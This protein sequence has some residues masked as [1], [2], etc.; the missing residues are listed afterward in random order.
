MSVRRPSS[1]PVWRAPSLGGARPD[2]GLRTTACDERHRA[3]EELERGLKEEGRLN[4]ER[5][6]ALSKVAAHPRR[7]A[8]AVRKFDRA[9][10]RPPYH[11]R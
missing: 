1:L 3:Q 7:L 4:L 2:F 5:N 8:R 9:D 10:R 6:A 11:A